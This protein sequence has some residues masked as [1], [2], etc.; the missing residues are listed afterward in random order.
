MCHKVLQKVTYFLQKTVPESQNK[1]HIYINNQVMSVPESL[2]KR[3]YN[4]FENL[5]ISMPE[6]PETGTNSLWNKVIS[7]PDIQKK[8]IIHLE[9]Q[10]FS[11]S[12]SPKEA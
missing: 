9:N 1:G 10:G 5:H 11:V 2:V 6:S 12:E 8:G 7:V 3:D 4:Y